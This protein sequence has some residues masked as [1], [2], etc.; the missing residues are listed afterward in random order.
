MHLVA[1]LEESINNFRA[2]G[3]ATVNNEHCF[4]FRCK[5]LWFV[6]YLFDLYYYLLLITSGHVYIGGSGGIPL[7][8]FFILC[9]KSRLFIE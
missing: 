3:I 7:I 4:W 2:D 8:L 1:F 9:R 5:F 6:K